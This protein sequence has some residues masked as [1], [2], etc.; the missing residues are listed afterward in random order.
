MVNEESGKRKE[1][2]EMAI[3]KKKIDEKQYL[4]I[5]TKTKQQ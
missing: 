4:H 5:K 2:K 1:S 3:L